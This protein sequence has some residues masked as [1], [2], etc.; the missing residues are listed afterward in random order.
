MKRSKNLKLCKI[1]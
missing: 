1:M